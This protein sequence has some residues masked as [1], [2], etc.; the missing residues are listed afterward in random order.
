MPCLHLWL[1][2]WLRW[3]R[4]CP[5]CR[6]TGFDPWAGKFL[7]RR[8]WQPTPIFL[9]REF[10]GQRS[11]AGYNPGGSQRV[12]H[13]WATNTFAFSTSS[14]GDYEPQIWDRICLGQSVYTGKNVFQT[15]NFSWHSLRL[16]YFPCP[17]IMCRISHKQ[18]YP[19][20]PSARS[21]RIP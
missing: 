5:Q 7:W 1:P 21:L 19:I 4:I 20:T 6:R 2:W 3:Q 8:E 13:H 15:W 12:R 10:H 11:L 16:R 9:P 18:D 17:L 14:C